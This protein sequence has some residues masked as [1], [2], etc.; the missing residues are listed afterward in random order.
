MCGHILLK[1]KGAIL[2]KGRPFVFCANGAKI[3]PVCCCNGGVRGKMQPNEAPRENGAENMPAK[4]AKKG[5][6]NTMPTRLPT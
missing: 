5:V 4:R 2:L 6:K 1:Q 3:R